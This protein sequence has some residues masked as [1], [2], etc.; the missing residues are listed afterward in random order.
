MTFYDYFGIFILLD[1]LQKS[2]LLWE[3]LKTIYSKATFFVKQK[4]HEVRGVWKALILD[5]L[6]IIF[7]VLKICKT[8][9]FHKLNIDLKC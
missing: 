1:Q 3:R 8:F 9:V 5:I 4:V 7:N 6:P 2:I